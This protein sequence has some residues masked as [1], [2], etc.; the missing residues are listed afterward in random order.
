MMKISELKPGMRRIDVTGRISRVEQP[1]EVQT[2]FGPGKIASCMIT[3]ESGSIK[4]TL[5]NDNIA[6]AVNDQVVAIEMG[7]VDSFRGE[8][9]LNVGRYGFIKKVEQ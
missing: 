6:L 4:V 1:R 8:L 9:Q 3:D 5:W 2:K 7:Y